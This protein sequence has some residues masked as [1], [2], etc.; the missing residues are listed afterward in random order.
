MPAALV[1]YELDRPLSILAINYRDPDNTPRYDEPRLIAGISFLS[2]DERLL[3][4]DDVSVSGR[5][6]TLAKELLIRH[7]VTTLVMKGEADIILFP[8]VT[9]CVRWPWL[10]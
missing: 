6:I 2:H 10:A 7:P 4:V 5:T 9:E 3:L 1:A 8:E